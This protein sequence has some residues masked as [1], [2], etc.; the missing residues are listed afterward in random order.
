MGR[1]E[2]IIGVY[3]LKNKPLLCGEHRAYLLYLMNR[4]YFQTYIYAIVQ[5][6]TEHFIE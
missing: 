3:V 6:I 5:T 2:G 4:M 1:K